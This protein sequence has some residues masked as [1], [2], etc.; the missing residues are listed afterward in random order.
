MCR[1][2]VNVCASAPPSKGSGCK[3][4]APL[5]TTRVYPWDPPPKR[6]L[7]A[8]TP[9]TEIPGCAV[10]VQKKRTKRETLNVSRD[11]CSCCGLPA[12]GYIAGEIDDPNRWSYDPVRVRCRGFFCELHRGKAIRD[13]MASL[14]GW[15]RDPVDRILEPMEY[16]GG[17]VCRNCQGP[18]IGYVSGRLPVRPRE[19][20]SRILAYKYHR[21]HF[22]QHHGHAIIRGITG[23]WGWEPG[24]PEVVDLKESPVAPITVCTSRK[25]SMATVGGK[26]HWARIGMRTALF[27]PDPNRYSD[28]EDRIES[29]HI[30]A[31]EDQRC[32]HMKVDRTGKVYRFFCA[33]EGH[34]CPL[35]FDCPLST[36][37]FE[38]VCSSLD[39][40]WVDYTNQEV[41]STWAM[42]K[43]RELQ[44]QREKEAHQRAY[45]AK[46][47]PPRDWEAIG[48]YFREY[49][50]QQWLHSD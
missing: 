9:A 15:V 46:F 6:I 8:T 45:E 48:E 44:R 33:F 35:K 11:R 28:N 19:G 4:R 7:V 5:F 3:P 10:S 27:F 17:P 18:A 37:S 22:C 50:H 16:L 29:A 36:L 42:H 21:F 23:T 1:P 32:V 39:R 47:G 12:V 31:I 26:H 20:G 14:Q 38:R 41:P 49:Y 30:V 43:Q 25:H 40:E 2:T 24:R 13:H 34:G